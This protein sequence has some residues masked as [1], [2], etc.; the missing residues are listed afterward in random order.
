MNSCLPQKRRVASSQNLKSST[1]RN[2]FLSDKSYLI[3][4]YTCVK[5]CIRKLRPIYLKSIR[6]K[7]NAVPEQPYEIKG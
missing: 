6:Y 1:A 5:A 3:G 7:V 2:L 4:Y